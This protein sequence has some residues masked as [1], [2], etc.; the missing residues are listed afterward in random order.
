MATSRTL[1][2]RVRAIMSDGRWRSVQDLRSEMGEDV[3]TTSVARRM[4][5][6]RGDGFNII[7]RMSDDSFEYR[8]VDG[9][10]VKEDLQAVLDEAGKGAPAVKVIGKAL[11]YISEGKAADPSALA[12]AVIEEVRSKSHRGLKALRERV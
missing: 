9:D 3:K 12:G 10:P 4:R 5:A 1:K 6:L 7:T 2:D 11:S 8:L